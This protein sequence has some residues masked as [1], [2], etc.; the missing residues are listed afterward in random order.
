M[1]IF[2]FF[3]PKAAISLHQSAHKAIIH[4]NRG[5]KWKD[6]KIYS[7]IFCEFRTSPGFLKNPFVVSAHF[8]LCLSK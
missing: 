4:A 3:E 2:L 6:R 8:R 7:S 5:M 1:T